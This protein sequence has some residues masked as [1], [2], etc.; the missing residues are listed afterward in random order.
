MENYR[1]IFFQLSAILS[2]HFLDSASKGG[3]SRWIRTSS[4]TIVQQAARLAF[5][6]TDEG[7]KV[8]IGRSMNILSSLH[9][10]II[11]KRHWSGLKEMKRSILHVMHAMHIV[12]L[13][14]L[15][16]RELS[17]EILIHFRENYL[18]NRLHLNRL[19]LIS[20][21]MNCLIHS[22]DVMIGTVD[23]P[24]GCLVNLIGSLDILQA[25][26]FLHCL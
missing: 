18:W 2:D 6:W 7:V 20:I 1:R 15:K 24:A 11:L 8:W 9:R 16:K 22:R 25:Q 12:D 13:Y 23:C 14:Q 19:T 3:S 4:I 5:S 17:L 26:G 21:I 10:P